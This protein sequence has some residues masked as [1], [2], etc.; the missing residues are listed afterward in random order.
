MQPVRLW[1][2]LGR[3]ED[4]CTANYVLL[5]NSAMDAKKL[6]ALACRYVDSH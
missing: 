2:R 6:D 5:I 1:L 3:A 4:Y